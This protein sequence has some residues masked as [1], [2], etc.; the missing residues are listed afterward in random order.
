MNDN[1]KQTQ[2][3]T[4]NRSL[5]YETWQNMSPKGQH[6]CRYIVCDPV[7]ARASLSQH[8]FQ[9]ILQSLGFLGIFQGFF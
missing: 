7:S 4:R 9:G 3:P 5:P 8:D 2:N 6:A 1:I